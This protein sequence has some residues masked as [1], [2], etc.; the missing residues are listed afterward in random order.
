MYELIVL[1]IWLKLLAI[2]AAAIA[3][4]KVADS[5]HLVFMSGTLTYVRA[6]VHFDCN[7]SDLTHV[8][9]SLHRVESTAGPFPT[10]VLD[11]S[12]IIDF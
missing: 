3:R 11:L 1:W 9:R 6:S 4:S 7:A 5:T 2:T 10:R 8:A 12:S